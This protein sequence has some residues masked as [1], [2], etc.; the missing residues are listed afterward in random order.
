MVMASQISSIGLE[1][2]P[3]LP[4]AHAASVAVS[5]LRMPAYRQRGRTGQPY[6]RCLRFDRSVLSAETLEHFS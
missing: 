6:M 1:V 4:I 3:A 2:A 5:P